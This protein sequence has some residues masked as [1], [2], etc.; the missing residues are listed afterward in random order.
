MVALFCVK[1]TSSLEGNSCLCRQQA[2]HP[3]SHRHEKEGPDSVDETQDISLFAF[4][5][6]I[7]PCSV[8]YL[9]DILTYP[10]QSI[11]IQ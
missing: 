9:I 6:H 2:F 8:I 10:F 7:D 11:A 5:N 4:G 3:D 1:L